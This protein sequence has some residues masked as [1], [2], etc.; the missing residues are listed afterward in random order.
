MDWDE[1]QRNGTRQDKNSKFMLNL[2]G[3]LS[4]IKIYA[5]RKEDKMKFSIGTASSNMEFEEDLRLIKSSLLYAD[6]IEL[7]G[8]AEYAIFNYLPKCLSRANDI[9]TIIENLIPFFESFDKPDTQRM[10][11]ELVG[12]K[13]KLEPLMP[14]LKKRKY[15][16]KE[17]L[18]AQMRMKKLTDECNN[19]LEETTASI[20]EQSGTKTIQ[21]LIDRRIV[22][23]YDYSYNG[24]SVDGLTGG[25]FAN[26]IGTIKHGGSYPLFDSICTDV[27]KAVV[28]SKILD[29]SQ[30]D[31]EIIRHAGIANNI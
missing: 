27:V 2:L 12:L 8:M 1:S 21:N 13:G 28:K 5:R 29:F 7:I 31:K 11:D 26:L 24:F 16:S 25:Y 14:L 3:S 20:L 30:T 17:E 23:V 22:S 4:I 6:E 9:E 18:L 10:A 19:I 15:R